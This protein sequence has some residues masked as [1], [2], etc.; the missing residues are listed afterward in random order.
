[1]PTS[2]ST[3]LYSIDIDIDIDNIDIGYDLILQLQCNV[4][5]ELIDYDVIILFP[6]QIPD[7]QQI[8]LHPPP[9]NFLI[10]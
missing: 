7:S 2:T 3:L 5:C 6:V 1:M 8:L 9:G 10:E 4:I